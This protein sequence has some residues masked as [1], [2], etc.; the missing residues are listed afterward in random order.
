[1]AG[2]EEVLSD[3]RP[4]H[5]VLP[6]LHRRDEK[7][8]NHEVLQENKLFEY[9]NTMKMTHYVDVEELHGALDMVLAGEEEDENPPV[10]PLRDAENT[11]TYFFNELQK[12]E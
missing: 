11:I 9:S 8:I 3:T 5:G 2:E 6:V 7:L 10:R 12:N 1:M 4:R